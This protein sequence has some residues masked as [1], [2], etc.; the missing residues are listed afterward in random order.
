[1]TILAAVD[2][3]AGSRDALR[4]AGELAQAWGD[5]LLVV[6]A[7]GAVVGPP[8]MVTIPG[9]PA[10]RIDDYEKRHSPGDVEQLA[11]A[12]VPEGV[13]VRTR[14]V[15]GTPDEVITELAR[16]EGA[17]LVVMSTHGR[18]GMEYMLQGSVAERVVRHSPCPV[19]TI[20]ETRRGEE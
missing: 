1:M 17:E 18:H 2:F 11:R 3:D 14:V 8:E 16:S 20:R 12:V 5:D 7:M 15:T 4:Y 6:H 13:E 19:L 10:E 9:H